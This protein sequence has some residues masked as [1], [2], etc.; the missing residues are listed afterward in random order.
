MGAHRHALDGRGGCTARATAARCDRVGGPAPRR[1][2][3]EVRGGRPVTRPRAVVICALVVAVALLAGGCRKVV[4]QTYLERTV[5]Q[6]LLDISGIEVDA[7][8]PSG[9]T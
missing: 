8:C 4:S 6:Y 9:E 5:E 1:A 2:R 3:H 7:R